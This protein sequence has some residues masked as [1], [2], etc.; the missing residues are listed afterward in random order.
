M[1]IN[2]PVVP[3]PGI[4]IILF[5][6]D[7]QY[8]KETMEYWIYSEYHGILDIFRIPWNTGYIQNT[9]EYWI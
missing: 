9:M 5:L 2:I 3:E 8:N 1:C 6:R 7:N 4:I